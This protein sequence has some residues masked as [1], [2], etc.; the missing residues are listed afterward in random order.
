[1]AYK[2]GLCRFNLL[3]KIKLNNLVFYKSNNKVSVELMKNF[4]LV[5]A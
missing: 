3:K 1:M 2:K 5:V 4:K